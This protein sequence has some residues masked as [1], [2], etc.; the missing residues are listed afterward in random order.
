[1]LWTLIPQISDMDTPHEGL[2]GDQLR[3]LSVS[4]PGEFD[5]V[6]PD[7]ARSSRLRK[8][9][10]TGGAMIAA[11]GAG[12]SGHWITW[13][14]WAHPDRADASSS[15][16]VAILQ[17]LELGLVFTVN[18]LRPSPGLLF[19]TARGLGGRGAGPVGAAPALPPCRLPRPS[20]MT[21]RQR[22]GR[23]ERGHR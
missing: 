2:A 7:I 10:S 4:K 9:V 14:W 21:R 12:S 11:G 5:E 17:D 18:F 22:H 13:D 6:G 15:A 23:Q 1:M 20:P 16:A 8:S 3:G 19:G